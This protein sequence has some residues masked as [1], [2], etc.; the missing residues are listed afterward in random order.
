MVCDA[1]T[2]T[3]TQAALRLSATSIVFV[4]VYELCNQLTHVRGNAGR[5]VFDWEH[6]IPFVPWT[7]VPYLSLIGFFALSFMVR[8]QRAQL[9][10]HAAAV[11]INLLLSAAC[12]LLMPLRFTFER[13]LLDGVWGLMF[14]LLSA[15]DLPYNRAPSLHISVLLIVWLRLSPQWQGFKKAAFGI[16]FVLIAL[17]VLTT[18]QHHVIDVPAGLLVGAASIAVARRM[19][20]PRESALVLRCRDQHDAAKPSVPCE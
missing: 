5:A 8:R 6:A 11:T 17:S 7:I 2:L 10:C 3:R 18:Y 1:T 19:A 12:Y 13:P 20:A 14:A 15:A 4:G 9:N 16:W